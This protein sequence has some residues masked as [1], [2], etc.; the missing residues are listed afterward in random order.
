MVI[1]QGDDHYRPN[2]DLAVDDNGFLLDSMHSEHGRLREVD[3]GSTV[4]GTKDAAVRARGCRQL[5]TARR[6]KDTDI[7]NVPPAISSSVSLLSL[8]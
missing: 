8:A 7:G 2:D 4:Q 1:R 6:K 3:Y 5:A